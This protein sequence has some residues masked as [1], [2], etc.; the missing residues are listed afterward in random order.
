MS[1]SPQPLNALPQ[2]YRLQ[3]YELV[4]VLGFGG[5]GMTYLGFD[6]N[7][8]KPVAIK[9]YLPSD[10]AT[11]TADRSVAAQASEVRGD[12]Q[13][14]LERFVDEAR[15]LA[16]FDHRHII[17]V[18]RFFEAHGTAYI[19]M[20]YAEGETLSAHLER[21]GTLQEA[22][23][24]AILYPL[25]N[26]LEVVHGADFLHRDIK[27]GNI[28][29][30]DS[31]GSPVL[32]D[33]G[34]A[35]QAIGAKSRSVTSIV[36]PGYAPIEQYSS[37]GHQG[38]WTDL[39]AL[40]GVCYRALTGEV[41]DDAT[42]RV[43]HDPLIP[44]AQRCAGRA[45]AAFL[46]AVDW[47]LSVDEGDR[48]QRVGA[49]R[50]AMEG[51]TAGQQ[52][53]RQDE[54][55]HGT[56][57]EIA[58]APVTA[59]AAS[60]VKAA[61]RLNWW[62]KLHYI[63]FAATFVVSAV[64]VMP[65]VL[66][67]G[68]IGAIES[69]KLESIAGVAVFY[70]MPVAIDVLFVLTFVL[71]L[72]FGCRILHKLWSLIPTH[73]VRTTPGKAVG[74]L[75][76]PLFRLY[77]AFVAIYGLAKALN[78]ETGRKSVSE[79]ASFIYCCSFA[80]SYEVYLVAL[81]WARVAGS[82]ASVWIAGSVAG[83]VASVLWFVMLR[84]MKN[85]GRLILQVVEQDGSP[86]E[87]PK[88]PRFKRLAAALG[89]V[90]VLVGGIMFL[91]TIHAS[92]LSEGDDHSDTRSGATS[93]SLGSS[94]P[95]RIATRDDVDYFKVE[96]SQAGGLTVYTT[97]NLDT[98]GTLKGS[99]G[100]HLEHDFRSGNGDNFRIE[101]SVS[102]GTYYVKVEGKMSSDTGDYTIHA[103][104]E[105]DDHSDTRSGATSL[106]LGSSLPG[107]IA[108]RDDVDYFK[109]EVSQAG[110]LTVYTTGNLD[111]KGTLEGSAGNRLERDFRSGN[112]DNFRIEHSVSAGTYY[113]KVERRTWS[114]TGD[115]TI[116]ARFEAD[117]HSDT[118]SGAT[119]LSLGSSLPGRIA[120]RDDVDYFKVEVSQ[121]GVLTV[122]T[123]G[124]L[125]TEGTLEGSAGNRL[126][127]DFRSGNGDNFR[128]EHSVSAGTYYVKVE[129][130]VRS[131]TGD[132]TIHARFEADD[133]RDTRSGATSLSL[134]SSLPGRIATLDDVDYFKVEVSQAGGLTVY[135]TG[136]LDT[137]G[138]LE[139][140]AGNHLE[141]DLWSGNG[142]NFRIEHSVSAGTYYVKVEG[143]MSSDTG[144]YTIHARF[145]GG[146]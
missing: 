115:Y 45:S 65:R 109:V 139:G 123:T 141:R 34:A 107:R 10:I 86:L 121:A 118:R 99:A 58:D 38:A 41:P 127:R 37:R 9:E 48:P 36:T 104:F 87:R 52:A 111:T 5:F 137:E 64:A 7:L 40:G 69:Q 105:A 128:I 6:H 35:R 22:E 61:R 3:E 91:I 19:V 28:V 47:A 83:S 133:H 140:S 76:I 12:F 39:Y 24:K 26:A 23:L 68:A 44:V 56:G 101:H 71:T 54:E 66:L 146:G 116:H 82:E 138:T 142:R 30:R 145:R 94:L 11:R 108:T 130:L 84:Q 122:Y 72:V 131:D 55:K 126:E 78:A 95:G 60:N 110:V 85:A 119:S 96:V 74:F 113:V 125:D 93:L 89:V 32:L 33:F 16:R 132:Y 136:N 63:C 29:L 100:N 90:A 49:W 31:D 134:G 25:L 18:H 97:G 120:T 21:K 53:H 4:R 20:D 77:W 15:T 80:I 103:R 8:D 67:I 70:I 129:G 124:N 27:P 59:Q 98:E 144:D 1:E 51:A 92:V 73:K 57:D 50:E 46:S 102:A 75:F 143:W 14:G 117:D 81:L 13:W 135:T 79:V 43:R 106:S 62:F 112:G 2:G 88:K 42:D 114:D 17:K